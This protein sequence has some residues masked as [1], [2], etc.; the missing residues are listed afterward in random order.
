MSVDKK[1]LK[2]TQNSFQLLAQ[3]GGRGRS[4]TF[5][6]MNTAA[7]DGLGKYPA[8]GVLY[9]S[10]D[11]QSGG[12]GYGFTQASVKNA[13]TFRG[14]YPEYVKYEKTNQCGGKR[15]RKSRRKR[16]TKR[17]R[18]S[19][20]KRKTK[21]RRKSRRR[22]NKKKCCK[23]C[24]RMCG[25][26]CKCSKKCKKKCKCKCP[27]CP[28]HKRRTRR[29]TRQRGG[30]TQVFA[31]P[32]PQHTVPWAT[33]PTSFQKLPPTCFDNYNHYTGEQRQ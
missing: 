17:R 9:E 13:D 28:R 5:D 6:S 30:S 18:K 19:R 26:S 29:R 16:K 1:Y 20:R 15:R 8:R 31:S 4:A 25:K 3:K 27:P 2:N 21:R 11:S 24:K 10:C 32:N 7:N 22:S 12:G 33:G 23:C 14:S